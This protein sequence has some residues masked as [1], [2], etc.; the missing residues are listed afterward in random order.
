MA[1]DKTLLEEKSRI[2]KN[3][4]IAKASSSSQLCINRRVGDHLAKEFGIWGAFIATKSEPNLQAVFELKN[5]TWAFPR[6]EGNDLKFYIPQ[7]P[8]QRSSLGIFEPNPSRSQLVPK[9]KLRGLLVPGVAFDKA[10]YRLGR[11]R[12]FYDRYLASFTGKKIGVCFSGQVLEQVPC[13]DHDIP[14]DCVITENIILRIP[15]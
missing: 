12:G 8:F 2:R 9:G 5:I 7:G 11:G 6:V 13:G 15:A 10:G 4:Q 14:M 3:A 1:S